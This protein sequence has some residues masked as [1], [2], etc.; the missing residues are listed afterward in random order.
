MSCVFFFWCRVLSFDRRLRQAYI[1]RTLA[2][3]QPAH[4]FNHLMVLLIENMMLN[5]E[6]GGIT[7]FKQSLWNDEVSEA[8][9]HAHHPWISESCSCLSKSKR[10][11]YARFAR[12]SV[13]LHYIICTY[14]IY[15][16][17]YIHYMIYIYIYVY[18]IYIYIRHGRSRLA[19]PV[20]VIDDRGA[21]PCSQS[22]A[23]WLQRR[24]TPKAFARDLGFFWM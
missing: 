13:H 5:I 17:V 21:V 10:C 14:I 1:S 2:Q 12:F 11:I 24:Y 22:L 16:N 4:S 3:F 18:I 23:M 20:D 7:C 19:N 6:L 15:Y 9:G 8:V